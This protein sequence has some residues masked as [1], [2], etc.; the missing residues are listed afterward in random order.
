MPLSYSVNQKVHSC[1]VEFSVLK[2]PP[3][4]GVSAAPIALGIWTVV[5]ALAGSAR[6]KVCTL[7]VCL[8]TLILGQ[9]L[10]SIQVP[11]PLDPQGILSTEAGIPLSSPSE[12][13]AA[14]TH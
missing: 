14:G 13:L 10:D 7:R 2:T 11:G 12:W 6:K 9:C 1:W 8:G 5:P 4:P 3:V